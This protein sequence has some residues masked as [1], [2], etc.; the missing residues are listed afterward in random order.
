MHV[1]ATLLQPRRCHKQTPAASECVGRLVWQVSSRIVL[2]SSIKCKQA[3]ARDKRVQGGSQAA[4]HR[5]PAR[6]SPHAASAPTC[7][8]HCARGQQRA[9]QL[10]LP[11]LLLLANAL[12]AP[13]V[14][15]S[16][17]AWPA[18][19]SGRQSGGGSGDGGTGGAAACNVQWGGH[20]RR[21][22]PPLSAAPTR[23]V[24]A[25]R[26]GGVH[27]RQEEAPC[28]NRRTVFGCA[29][30]KPP[31]LLLLACAALW[32]ASPHQLLRASTTP[33]TRSP[34]PARPARL[35]P[36]APQHQTLP[37][38]AVHRCC[39][40]VGRVGLGVDCGFWQRRHAGKYQAGKGAASPLPPPPPTVSPAACAVMIVTPPF[41]TIAGQP[42]YGEII[43]SRRA[44]LVALTAPLM[45]APLCG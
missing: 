37:S 31:H 38:S 32:P 4:V 43:A 6:S 7:C 19:C 23:E 15:G 3:P 28:P 24:A 17:P 20:R 12:P 27:T 45:P 11:H 18:G 36:Q 2:L 33:G 42:M 8:R 30:L 41:R 5:R 40:S 22:A 16:Q 44:C 35:P 25:G 34:P 26:Q 9:C 14:A 39:C 13:S 10:L 29:A 1:A 21:Q